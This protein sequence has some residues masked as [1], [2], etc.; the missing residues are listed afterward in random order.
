MLRAQLDTAPSAPVAGL[1]ARLT[2]DAAPPATNGDTQRATDADAS[3]TRF[4]RDALRAR[5][6]VGRVMQ[7]TSTVTVFAATD[8]R[9]GAAAE[10]RTL[11]PDIARR[12][13][14]E[15]LV[16]TLERASR[17][18]HDNLAPI[19]DVGVVDRFVFMASP[20]LGGELLRD[21]LDREHRVSVVQAIDIAL[22]L[23]AALECIEQYAVPHLD[24]TPRRVRLI[25]G[26]VLLTDFGIMFGILSALAPDP[27]ESG[28]VLGTPAYMSPELLSGDHSTG[29]A[30]DIYS[31]GCILFHLLTGEPPHHAGTAR[32]LTARRLREPP[33][34]AH[35]MR[36]DVPVALDALLHDALATRVVDRI[37]SARLLDEQLHAV[38]ATL[39]TI[40]FA[41]P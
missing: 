3:Y 33:P 10:L 20:P 13:Q 35:A 28:V 18:R 41:F 37:G 21:R 23:A 16:A 31:L 26:S 4:V 25:D 9:S 24:L 1:V 38:R 15:P 14:L 34:S 2:Q 19:A 22:R 40:P 11:R 7:R 17:V 6:V 36:A 39:P 5:Y 27:T 29:A 8:V 30:S 12:L 32:A